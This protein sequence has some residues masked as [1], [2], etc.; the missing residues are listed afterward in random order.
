MTINT[1]SRWRRLWYARP[2]RQRHLVRPVIS[3][4]NLSLGGRGKTPVVAH[5]AR[6]LVDAGERP[7]ILT[8]GYARSRPEDGV[9]VVSDGTH[10]LADVDRG[11]DE[12]LMLARAVPGASVLVCDDRALAGALA[13]RAFGATVHLLDDGF[14]HLQLARD[15]DIVIITAADL[16]DRPVPMGRLRESVAALAHADAVLV[17]GDVEAVATTAP[18]FALHRTLGAP[19]PLEPERPWRDHRGPVVAVAGIAQPDRFSRSLVADG[20]TVV[21]TLGFG[22]HHPYTAAD[23]ARIS[24]VAARASARVVTTEKDAMRLLPWRPLPVAMAA[25]PLTVT[26]DPAEAFRAWF[27]DRLHAVQHHVA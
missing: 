25:V 15:L 3:V 2:D 22:D 20:W 21:E 18:V 8:R 26:I 9:V 10:L 16:A 24:E 19:V 4:G 27:F 5:L 17:D 12:P 1:F 6:L 11:G 7:A 23:L 13:E 14:Q